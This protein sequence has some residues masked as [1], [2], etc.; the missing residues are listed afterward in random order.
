MAHWHKVLPGYILDVD[1]ELL[2]ND[3]VGQLRRILEFC[4]L[5]WEDDCMSF[6]KSGNTAIT[7]S[8]LQVK[9]PLYKGAV[10]YWRRYE[11]YL[12]SLKKVLDK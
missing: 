4:G 6:H 5:P 12:G 2:V 7:A 8:S 11:E 10:D 3:Q 1:Y 9:Q